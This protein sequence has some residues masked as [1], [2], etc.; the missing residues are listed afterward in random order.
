MKFTEQEFDIMIE[1]LF[2]KPSRFEML[3]RI[4]RTDLEGYVVKFVN[5]SYYLRKF[6]SADDMLQDITVHVV[7]KAFTKFLLRNGPAGGINRDPEGFSKW[8]HTTARNLML[9]QIEDIKNR[10]KHE[11]TDGATDLLVAGTRGSHAIPEAVKEDLIYAFDVVISSKNISIYKVL[12]WLAQSM[13]FLTF[14]VTRIE[15]TGMLVAEFEK[16]TLFEIYEF[17][18]KSYEYLPWLTFTP[19]HKEILSE[20]LNEAFNDEKVMGEITYYE[21]FM[22]KGPKGSISDWINRLDSKIKEAVIKR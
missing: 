10:L 18:A 13:F 20:A 2:S 14:D 1:E 22:A 21:F 11:N 8:L 6:Y 19:R 5:S 4:V 15:A 16:K 17:V 7:K 3:C 9:D 12:T